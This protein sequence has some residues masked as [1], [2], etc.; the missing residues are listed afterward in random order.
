[1]YALF[2][3]S[4]ILEGGQTMLT[5]RHADIPIISYVTLENQGVYLG[6]DQNLPKT[7]ITDSQ[8]GK[9]VCR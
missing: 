4:V 5:C 8:V 6:W 9:S 2:W 1:M 7:R 3:L